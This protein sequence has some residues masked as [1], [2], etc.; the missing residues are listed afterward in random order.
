MFNVLL[1]WLVCVRTYVNAFVRACV[2]ASIS[3]NANIFEIKCCTVYVSIIQSATNSQRVLFSFFHDS[4]NQI[5]IGCVC[6]FLPWT[7]SLEF[8]MLL[9]HIV[10]FLFS[11]CFTVFSVSF[12]FLFPLSS[13]M[14][15]FTFFMRLFIC[16]FFAKLLCIHRW[17]CSRILAHT[18][19]DIRALSVRVSHVRCSSEWQTSSV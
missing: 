5:E 6:V 17:I 18:C 1:H 11:V 2:C 19:K 12:S 4:T 14:S 10:C 7:F 3:G 16:F 9:F 8:F 15:T 13:K